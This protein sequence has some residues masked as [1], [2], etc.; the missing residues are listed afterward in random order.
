ME[1]TYHP[2][3]FLDAEVSLFENVYS[4]IPKKLSHIEIGNLKKLRGSGIKLIE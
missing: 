1:F 4:Q 3:T 2:T